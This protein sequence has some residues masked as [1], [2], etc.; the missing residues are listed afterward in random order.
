MRVFLNKILILILLTILLGGC[1]SFNKLLK[2]SNFGL[3]YDK[4]IEYFNKKDY[5]KSL[6]LL[7]DIIPYYRASDESEE[8]NF[9][10]AYCNYAT[11]NYLVAATRFKQNFETWPFGK[12]AEQNLYYFA[13]SLYMESPP[14]EL[15]QTYTNDAIDA[16]LMFVNKYPE[17]D[18]V[19]MCNKYIDDLT[20]KLEEKD[21]RI[22]KLF[23]KIE[24][25]RAALWSIRIVL[26]KYPLT[27]QKAELQY[28]IL[29]S[30]FKTAKYSI[31]SKKQ[32]RLKDAVQYYL[33]N[34]SVYANTKFANQAENVY[35]S[36]L[37][38][39]KNLKHNGKKN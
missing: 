7:E 26:E 16:M 17:S 35:Q 37:N 34:K 9:Y 8:L 19:E 24:D 3:K 1:N 11:A 22:A 15:D 4:A 20:E 12:Y 36:A 28:Y 30:Y 27:K 39:L 5:A 13:Y 32:E 2:S 29:N 14:V 18:K 31:E 23:Y 6:L 33:D 10:Y 21:I 38:N 25:Y